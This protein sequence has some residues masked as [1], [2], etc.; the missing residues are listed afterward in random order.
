[1]GRIDI[2]VVLLFAIIPLVALARRA[3]IAYPIVLVLSGLVL[4]FIPGL[5]AVPLPP[6]TIL[7]VFL[8][9]LLYWEALTA[10][11]GA[12]RENAGIVRTLVIGLVIATTTV[13]AIVAHAIVPHLPWP[14]A[15]VI[16]AVVSPTDAVAFAPVA[17]RI[18]VPARTLAIVQAEGLLNDGTALVIYATAVAAVVSGTFVLRD[19]LLSFTISSIAAILLGIA[20]GALVTLIWRRLRDTDLQTAVS[21]IA[22][23]LAF[24]PAHHL[25][26]SGVVAVVSASLYINRFAISALTAEARQ[27]AIGLGQS[28]AFLMNAIIFLLVGLQLHPVLVKLSVYSRGTLLI[29]ALAISLTVIAVRFAWIFG[30][31][32]VLRLPGRIAEQPQ[33]E[34]KLRFVT[35]WA[36]FRG[37]VSLAAALAIPQTVASGVDFPRRQLIVFL[38]F[39]VILFTLVGQGLTFPWLLGKLRLSSDDGD[40]R[41]LR[42]IVGRISRVALARLRRLEHEEPDERAVFDILRRHYTLRAQRYGL[43]ARPE[44]IDAAR[45]YHHAAREL[46]AVQRAELARL[47]DD[48]TL[49]SGLRAKVESM[50]DLEEIEL[51]EFAAI[52]ARAQPA[53]RSGP[54]T[55]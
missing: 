51:D 37:G 27:R 25:G 24:L 34:W 55:R 18:G 8:P 49:D 9:P 44:H 42:K 36:G 5:P 47:Q 15:F 20:V 53:T 32:Y 4:G 54:A 21:V 12:M 38:T 6:D 26:I 31:R 10:P 1:M 29:M 16:G 48:G 14:V 3:N 2:V 23:F 19:A 17:E 50:L 30:Q 7:L 46:L 13:V 45:G 33:D 11:I 52:P 43:D 22:P 39:G 40:A 28:V 41:E 35:A